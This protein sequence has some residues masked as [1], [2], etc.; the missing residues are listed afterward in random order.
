M[1]RFLFPHVITQNYL[2]KIMKIELIF[3]T[4]FKSHEKSNEIVI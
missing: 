2:R 3:L 1:K 4:K